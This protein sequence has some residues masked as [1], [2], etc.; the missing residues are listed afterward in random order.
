[1]IDSLFAFQCQEVKSDSCLHER[2]FD[3][4]TRPS[5]RMKRNGVTRESELKKE[6]G[7][8]KHGGLRGKAKSSKQQKAG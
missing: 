2:A 7:S 8:A 5:M 4:L 1:M 3:L 6:T